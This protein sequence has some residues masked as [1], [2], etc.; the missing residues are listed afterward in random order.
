MEKSHS[1]ARKQFF[2]RPAKDLIAGNFKLVSITAST[3]VSAALGSLLTSGIYGAPVANPGEDPKSQWIGFIELADIVAFIVSLFH[4]GETTVTA[5]DIAQ[6]ETYTDE[7]LNKIDEVLNTTSV[8]EFLAARPTHASAW[9][10][11]D[12]ATLQNVVDALSSRSRVVLI[13]RQSGNIVGLLS[14][15]AL[16]NYFAKNMDAL[17]AAVPE[18]ITQAIDTAHI[19][20]K[21]KVVISLWSNEKE[22]AL[23]AFAK[24]AEH[25]ISHVALVTEV[26]GN[27]DLVGN[28]SV[29]DVK[30]IFDHNEAGAPIGVRALL[31]PVGPYINKI[32]QENLK[33]IH[34]AIHATIEGHGHEGGDTVE[35]CILKLAATK[36]HRM[37]VTS[38]GEGAPRALV[39]VVSLGD[40]VRLFK[41][42]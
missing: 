11:D 40:L 8:K 18:I 10:L 15:S 37:Y 23:D 17:A 29:K 35:K 36:I 1:E 19:V 34:P 13:S 21:E 12:T 30:S 25:H 32:R 41:S 24:M 16:I 9:S 7:Q 6:H 31:T 27:Y 42:Q 39:G 28:V 20:K 38:S 26:S 2:S 33:A 14:R 22:R 4:K 5:A 3:P